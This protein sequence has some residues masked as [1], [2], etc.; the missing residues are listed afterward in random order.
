MTWVQAMD[1]KVFGP[2]IDWAK[3][4]E[5]QASLPATLMNMDNPNV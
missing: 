4:A 1:C 2:N 5:H 3:R